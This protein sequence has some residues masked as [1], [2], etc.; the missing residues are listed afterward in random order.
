MHRRNFVAAIGGMSI[1]SLLAGEAAAE[2]PVF[3]DREGRAILG[4]DVVMFWTAKKAVRGR[5]EYS[6]SW[7][8][9]RWL[10][11]S[12]ENQALFAANPTKYAPEYGGHCTVSM[13]D[14]KLTPISEPAWSIYRGRLFLNYSKR[15]KDTF[16]F[17]S[18]DGF[19]QKADDNWKAKYANL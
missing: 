18:T 16:D 9:A 8:G 13:A 12:A 10:F 4:Y 5:D 1:V 6:F 19:V 3:R 2:P 15:V 7:R 17:G 11:A 14:G